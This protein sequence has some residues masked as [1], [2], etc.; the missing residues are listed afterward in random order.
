M[1]LKLQDKLIRLAIYLL[2]FTPFAFQKEGL[3]IIEPPLPIILFVLALFASQKYIT[4]KLVLGNKK[5]ANAIR[6][7]ATVTSDGA[8]RAPSA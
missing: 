5:S 6:T 7:Y 2:P 4:N 3:G 1:Q 8:L